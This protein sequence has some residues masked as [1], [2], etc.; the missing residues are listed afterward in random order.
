MATTSSEA[1]NSLVYKDVS[2]MFRDLIMI[3]IFGGLGCVFVIISII[4]ASFNTTRTSIGAII[5]YIITFI[6]TSLLIWYV[7][8]YMIAKNKLKKDLANFTLTF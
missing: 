4:L 7:I 8:V 6:I 5:T 2:R 1:R 3:E